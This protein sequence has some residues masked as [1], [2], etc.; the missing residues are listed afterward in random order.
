M[1]AEAGG[2]GGVMEKI[3]KKDFYKKEHDHWFHEPCDTC[4]YRFSTLDETQPL[5]D[6]DQDQPNCLRCIH[7]CH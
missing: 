4:I 2:E 7:F 1:T 3:T 6:Q 5:E